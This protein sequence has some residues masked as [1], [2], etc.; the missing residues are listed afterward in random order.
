[1]PRFLEG[2]V[3]A[4]NSVHPGWMN[5][6]VSCIFCEREDN[7]KVSRCQAIRTEAG[8]VL[9]EREQRSHHF[10]GK[11]ILTHVPLPRLLSIVIV[12]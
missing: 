3:G 4:K 5:N 1:M 7:R 11:V 9:D 8:D 6:R 2:K 10:F 12:P